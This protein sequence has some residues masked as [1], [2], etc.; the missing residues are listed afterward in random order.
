MKSCK[1]LRGIVSLFLSCTLGIAHAQATT[2]LAG[3]ALGIAVRS[4]DTKIP[5]TS[6]VSSINGQTSRNTETDVSLV[7]SWGQVLSD[8]WVA[9]VG[10]SYAP[11]K[12][13]MGRIN[14][15]SGGAQ[16]FTAQTKDHIALF[17]A[18]GYRIQPQAVL[19]GKLAYHRLTA[20]YRDTATDAS[21]RTFT[22]SGLGLGL[23]YALGRNLEL[24]AEYEAVRYKSELINLTTGKPGQ[25]ILSG[26]LLYKF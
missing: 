18:P 9:M 8:Q 10:I 3:P 13:D 2:P 12:T 20:D 19:Y 26:S 16:N 4:L 7:G 6:S 11:G 22:G 21:S 25:D 1:H 24:R 14:Y 23:A 5:Y 15:T 17:M